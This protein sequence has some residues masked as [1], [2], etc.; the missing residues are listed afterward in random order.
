MS[1]DRRA[2]SK[3][4]PASKSRASGSK[5][6]RS[7][8][9]RKSPSGARRKRASKPGP[10]PSLFSRL[11]RLVLLLAGLGLGLLVPWTLWLNHLITTEFE[12]RKW[13][14]PSRVFA[15]PLSLFAQMP[16]TALPGLSSLWD[17]AGTNF[18]LDARVLP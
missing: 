5:G 13:D 15:R 17:T 12:G 8:A 16:L 2:G 6:A 18:R 11:L 3:K 7:K 1:A 10:K 9:A 14:L 4:K